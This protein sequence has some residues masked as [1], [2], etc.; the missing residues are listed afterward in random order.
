MYI[1]YVYACIRVRMTCMHVCMYMYVC[2]SMHGYVCMYVCIVCMCARMY[3]CVY[4]HA[5][6]QT[7]TTGNSNKKK[8]PALPLY[9]VR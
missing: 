8:I 6:M 9:D 5:G 7:C 2:R 3:V 1:M 4:A